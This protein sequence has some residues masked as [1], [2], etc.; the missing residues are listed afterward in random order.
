MRNDELL[1]WHLLEHQV[2]AVAAEDGEDGRIAKELVVA[3][4]HR[5]SIVIGGSDHVL[6]QQDG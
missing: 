2:H 4:A 5:V 3:E 1:I 6:D